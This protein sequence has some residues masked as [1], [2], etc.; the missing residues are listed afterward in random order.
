MSWK[1]D[2]GCRQIQHTVN[3]DEYH[4]IVPCLHSVLKCILEIGFPYNLP[5]LPMVLKYSNSKNLISFILGLMS[6][7]EE[8]TYSDICSIQWTTEYRT[9]Y[10]TAGIRMVIFR[11]LFVS[12]F[13]MVLAA[14]LFLPFENRTFCPV[15]WWFCP[16]FEWSGHSKTGPKFYNF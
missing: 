9:V 3:M 6:V 5:C 13:R 12:G 1:L 11:T 4:Y 8:Y 10:R 2:F 16:V 7:Y 14:I 15:L